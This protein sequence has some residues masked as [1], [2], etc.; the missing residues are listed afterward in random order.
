MQD[1]QP[2][3][4]EEAQGMI[5]ILSSDVRLEWIM[6]AKSCKGYS[7][8]ARKVSYKFRFDD[9][10]KLDP[11]S[12]HGKEDEFFLCI[13]INRKGIEELY[14]FSVRYREMIDALR[15]VFGDPNKGD[16]VER[17]QEA[18]QKLIGLDFEF[19]KRECW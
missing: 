13:L 10:K 8:Y 11:T 7:R 19:K 1:R 2:I 9:F 4:F 12:A 17:L 16:D 15:K 5:N 14:R 18:I 6:I 3:T